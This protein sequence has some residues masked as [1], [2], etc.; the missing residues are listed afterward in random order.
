[1]AKVLVTGA[2]GFVGKRIVYKLLEQGHEVYALSRIRGIELKVGPQSHFHEIYGD[3]RD[4]GQIEP[5]PPDLDAVYYLVHSMGNM[6]EN[7][8]EEEKMIAHNFIKLLE[9]TSCKQIIYLGGII[10]NERQ[11]SPHLRARLVVEDVLKTS[12]IPFT[13]LR[14]SIIIGAGSASFEII[15]DLVEKLPM[16]IAPK[17]VKS[18]CQ[19][20]SIQD[21]LFYLSGVLLNK[22]CYGHTYD[23]GGPEVFSFKEVLLRYA[24]FRK[25]KRYIFDVPLLTPRLSSY[26]LV[27]I[28]SVRISICRY[29]VESMKQIRVS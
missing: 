17:W 6:V 8:L 22:Q 4:P 13:I 18:Y 27:L 20:I 15:R 5:L 26:W 23:L 24:S 1:M 25:L 3:L 11:L 21:V 19:P 7:L 16:M 12:K 10:E 14:A 2:T 28:T 9:K 29:L